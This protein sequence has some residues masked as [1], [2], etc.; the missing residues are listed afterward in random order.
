MTRH[1]V[2]QFDSVLILIVSKV[3]CP[4]ISERINFYKQ[5]ILSTAVRVGRDDRQNGAIII[6][7]WLMNKC[8]ETIFISV[9][10][11]VITF[12]LY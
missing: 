8:L 9:E 11:I 5:F 3:P 4:S 12:P 7:I 1:P 10:T 6:W 2:L